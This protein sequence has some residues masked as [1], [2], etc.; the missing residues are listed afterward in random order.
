MAAF[1][2]DVARG[3]ARVLAASLAPCAALA[4]G[5]S[6]PFEPPG[7]GALRAADARSYGV[8]AVQ[9]LRTGL[10]PAV[11]VDGRWLRV[12]ESLA[13]GRLIAVGRDGA[14]FRAADG[15]RHRLVPTAAAPQAAAAAEPQDGGAPLPPVKEKP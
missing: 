9:G 10:A 5:A 6:A 12:G 2:S 4:A 8:P 3:C 14:V 11:L 15:S 7:A 13:G 1:V